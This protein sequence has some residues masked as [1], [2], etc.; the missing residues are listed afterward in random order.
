MG[1]TTVTEFEALASICAAV[2]DAIDA[3]PALRD[4]ISRVLGIGDRAAANFEDLTSRDLRHPPGAGTDELP[5]VD[6]AL[7][8]LA[9]SPARADAAATRLRAIAGLVHADPAYGRGGAKRNLV[10]PALTGGDLAPADVAPDLLDQVERA[11]TNDDLRVVTVNTNLVRG[12]IGGVDLDPVPTFQTDFV[13]GGRTLEDV[14]LVLNPENW[15]RC[16]HWWSEMVLQDPAGGRP[17]YRETVAESIGFLRVDVCLQFVQTEI[18]DEVVL[19][20]RMC[21]VAAHQPPT[22]R[23]VVD[24]GWIVGQRH[25][26]GVR[27]RT[28]KRVQFADTIGGRSLVPT[29]VGLGYGMLAEELVD[30]CLECEAAEH[31]WAPV[32]VSDG[33]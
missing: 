27:I 5:S 28:S 33:R 14:K 6:E 4:P 1:M 11:Q 8:Q 7:A 12:L 24:E 26:D 21:D 9:A 16:C 3:D 10:L 15:P 20:Y 31:N 18:P 22:P 29:A 13:R 19:D 23:V 32:E 17:H 2:G 30:S 25:D